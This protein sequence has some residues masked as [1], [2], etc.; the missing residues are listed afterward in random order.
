MSD[1]KFVPAHYAVTVTDGLRSRKKQLTRQALSD[2]ATTLFAERG[3]DAVTTAEIA[4]AAGVAV[5]TVFNYFRTKEDLFFDRADAIALDLVETVT[6]RPAGLG[7]VGA[8]RLW[9][10][11]EIAFLLD[12]RG[13][14][15]TLR[16]FRVIAA[17]PALL[18]AEQRL[19]HRLESTLTEVLRTPGDDPMTDVLA[20]LLL[21]A[22]RAVLTVVR[23]R[24]LAGVPAAE[25]A[26]R[27]TDT[28]FAALTEDVH[29]WGR[30]TS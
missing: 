28:A 24:T 5:G 26:A 7:A 21:A 17:S 10:D 9:H 16:F 2:A 25:R 15:A 27:T 22:H 13:A 23:T 11:R 20:A 14:A 18:A 6:T 12:P 8:F 30:A 4:A 1:Y 19:H 29:A 3:F